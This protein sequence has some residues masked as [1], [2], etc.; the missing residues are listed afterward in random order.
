MERNPKM[1]IDLNLSDDVVDIVGQGYDVAIRIAPLRVSNLITHRISTNPRVLFAS[2]AYQPQYGVPGN[3][4]ELANH[5]CSTFHV[6]RSL[7][8]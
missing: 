5:Q 3:L 1:K 8:R 7:G 6:P 2:P 4:A